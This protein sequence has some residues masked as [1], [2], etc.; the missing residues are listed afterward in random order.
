MYLLHAVAWLREIRPA[1]NRS[2]ERLSFD[3]SNGAKIVMHSQI[4]HKI[5]AFEYVSGS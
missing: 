4:F 3:A 1:I 5:A 2:S